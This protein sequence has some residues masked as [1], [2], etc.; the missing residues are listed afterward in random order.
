MSWLMLTH[1][2][3]MCSYWE[4][5]GTS[6]LGLREVELKEDNKED[7]QEQFRWKIEGRK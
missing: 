4:V 1:G 7:L 3:L 5:V 2:R 6:L